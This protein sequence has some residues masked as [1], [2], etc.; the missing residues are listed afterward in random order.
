MLKTLGLSLLLWIPSNALAEKVVDAD[1]IIIK[2]KTAFFHDELF[3]GKAVS[4]YENGQKK[5]ETNYKDGKLHRTG[6]Q[7]YK[8]GQKKAEFNI[9]DGKL[10]GTYWYKS[11]QKREEV[12][13]KDDMRYGTSSV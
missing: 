2:N 7:W 11:G 6:T 1:A 13:Y 9:I 5:E 4:Y 10:H 8:D 12:N 3:T